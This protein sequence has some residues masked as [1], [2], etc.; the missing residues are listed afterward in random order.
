MQLEVIKKFNNGGT[1]KI[2]IKA[3]HPTNENCSDLLFK[4]NN[5]LQKIIREREFECS[6][7]RVN[8]IM[9]KA[10]W[11]HYEED[12]QLSEIE[13]DV[14]KGDVKSI[15][16]KLQKYFPLYS[17]F[18]SD[19][20][21]SESDSEIQDPLKYAVQQIIKDSFLQDKFNE[22]AI[23]VKEK[24]QDVAGRTL[25]KIQE[26][27][28]NLAS[29][30]NPVIPE[31]S[32]LKWGD[33]FKNVSITGDNDI[34][35]DKRGSGVKRLILL[36]FFRAEAERRKDEKDLPSIIYAI[37]EPETSQHADYQ[38][39]LTKAFLELS[40]TPNTQIII[41]THSSQIVKQLEFLHI[42]LVRNDINGK[43]IENV[44]PNELPYPSLNEVNYLAFSDIT[45]EYHNELY[46]YIE[47]EKFLND[48][49]AGKTQFNYI[50]ITREGHQH[51]ENKILSEYIR[52]QIHH[53]ENTLNERYTPEQLMQSINSMRDFIKNKMRVNNQTLTQ[54]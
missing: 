21:N 30:L 27:D 44:L 9:R 15:Y 46:G 22:I 12:L 50:K 49:R 34:P 35:M 54:I 47:S 17:L 32:T 43:I 16:E 33:V 48:Y 53:P 39:K 40:G 37:E 8:A 20:K 42:R 14:T 25:S 18:Q 24:L 10:I 29:T 38:K 6:D 1:A 7:K 26:M 52:H 3:N 51:N 23:K 41:T 13:I 28:T 11:E 5:D 19:R 36:N 45:E 2:Y 31:A 4:T